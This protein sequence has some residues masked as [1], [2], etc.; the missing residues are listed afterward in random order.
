MG[1]L[2]KCVWC[3]SWEGSRSKYAKHLEE[4]SVYKEQLK[5]RK[6]FTKEELEAWAKKRQQKEK[7][8]IAMVTPWNVRCGI[9]SYTKNL[10]EAIANLGHEVYIVRLNRF[11]YKTRDYFITLAQRFPKEFDIIVISHEYGLYNGLEADFY[12]T[13]KHL[14]PEK[15]IVTICHAV[16][17]WE[18]DITISNASSQVVVHNVF[19]ARKF[20]QKCTIIPHGTTP[21]ECPP[22]EE[23]RKSLAIPPEAPI[24][25]YVGFISPYKG[26]EILIE[27]M[28][29]VP[30]AALVIGGGWHKTGPETQYIMDL[31]AHSLE[32]LEGRCQWLGYVPDEQMKIAYGS[33]TVLC[34]CSRWATES[35]AL[36]AGLSHGRATIASSLP[37][38]KEKEELGALM[39]FENVEDLKTKIKQLLKDK[40]LRSKLEAGARNYCKQTAWSNIAKAHVKLYQT[41]L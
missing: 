16:G 18:T 40:K 12:R 6:P 2:M 20:A 41:L 25:G 1:E 14:Y 30:E 24:V 13:L 32:V 26:L 10:S 22:K 35:G 3:E 28:Q 33:F 7:M 17:N 4:C 11:G 38:F 5:D 23:C 15:P 31:K 21:T 39:T 29:G 9:A 34:Y 8:K 27:A 36:L 37:P 19:C